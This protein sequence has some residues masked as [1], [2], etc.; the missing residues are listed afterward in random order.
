[1]S[2]SYLTTDDIILSCKHKTNDKEQMLNPRE[3]M[4]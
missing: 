4:W 2:Y 1:M 3:Q